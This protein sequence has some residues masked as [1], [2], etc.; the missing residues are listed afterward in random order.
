M[1]ATGATASSPK[2]VFERERGVYALEVLH[3]IAHAVVST[4]DD[5]LRTS[6]QIHAFRTLT[7]ADIPVFLVKMHRT[8]VTF[9]LAGSDLARAQSTLEASGFKATTRRD[10]A[11][12]SVRAASM[13]DLHGVMVEIA[14][15]LA[16]AG[17]T[18]FETG[19]SHNSVQCLVE[20]NKVEAS[21]AR[22]REKFHL[23]AQAIK[24]AR[25]EKDGAA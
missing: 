6:R 21:L 8:A 2:I 10:L 9:A 22:L 7:D 24:E 12:I 19:D 11:L 13:R 25:F 3:D 20:G 16:E 17:A 5:A 1:A 4:G 14:D 15:A 23:D 18:L